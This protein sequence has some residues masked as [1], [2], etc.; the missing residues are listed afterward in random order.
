MNGAWLKPITSITSIIAHWSFWG[1]AVGAREGLRVWEGEVERRIAAVDSL[2]MK[3]N[4]KEVLEEADLSI[5]L[6]APLTALP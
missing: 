6:L 3:L 1:M 5:L 4:R 2:R